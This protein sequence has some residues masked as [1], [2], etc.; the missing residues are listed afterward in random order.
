MR[1]VYEVEAARE[2]TRRVGKAEG[3]GVFPPAPSA[4]ARAGQSA[5]GRYFR[6]ERADTADHPTNPSVTLRQ[7]DLVNG[8]GATAAAAAPRRPYPGECGAAVDG[9]APNPPQRLKSGRCDVRPCP[10]GAS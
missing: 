7:L 1:P 2:K 4:A 5:G 9:R 10:V 6:P 3:A 8:K